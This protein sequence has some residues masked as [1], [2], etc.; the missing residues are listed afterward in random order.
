M[1]AWALSQTLVLLYLAA[2]PAADFYVAPNGSDTNPGTMA[3][4]F[5]SIERARGAVRGLV[6]EG[7]DKDVVVFVRGGTYPLDATLTFGPEDSGT[8][9]HAIT[10]A[11]YPGEKPVLSGGRAI[12]GWKQTDGG[13]WQVDLSA[14]KAIT[15]PF[16]QLFTDGERLTRGR[17]PNGDALLR[18]E[19]VSSDV[20][21]ITLSE[22]PSA[23]NLA[24]KG[25]ELVMYQNWSISRVGV[26]GSEGKTV[27]CA[28][29]VGWIGHGSATTASP[30]KPC[31]IENAPEFVDQPGEWYWDAQSN[32]LTYMAAEGEDPNDRE[33]VAPQLHKLIS[34]KGR[35]GAP[36]RNLHFEGLAFEH[37]GW[38]VED[39]GYL[40]IQA[41]HHGTHTQGPIYVLPMAIEFLEAVDC[42]VAQC[43]VAHTGA[44]GITFGAG[45]Q[46]NTVR[47]CELYDIGG[48]GIMVG[49]RG[50][51]NDAGLSGLIGD[52]ALSND[53]P[54]ASDVPK[55]NSIANNVLHHCAAV[56][57][58][59]VGIY[60]AFCDGTRI[61]HNLVHDMPYTGISIGFRWNES[62][63]SQRNALLECNHVHDVM[64]MLADGGAIYTLGYQP[65][66]V[67]RGNLLHHAHRSPFAHGG[68]P[69]NGIFFDQGSK[70]Y[71]VE[72]N[73]IYETSGEPIRF[74][75]THKDNLT[76]KDNSFGVAPGAPGFPEAAAAKAGPAP[77]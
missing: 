20:K 72:G 64:K 73:I 2:A 56:S 28:N 76:W 62:E 74:N 12:T 30:G 36:V 45:C 32:V 50:K 42:E 3:A 31:Y 54:Q 25:A 53:W 1:T 11:A 4:P 41:G 6:K 24:G 52:G 8:A 38:A 5:A 47:D 49:W 71:H 65:G 23:E 70:G 14:Q 33:F 63:T 17:Y 21:Q 26:A 18:V 68:A 69:N 16:R 67:L 39:Y 37:V 29:P 60:D 13:K 57:H 66:T 9:E 40:G 75:Q 77:R 7:L 22:A 35:P 61:T 43:R 59:C 55:D 51:S 15:H 34:V 48:N 10:Y 19:S 27:L 58:G 46:A 44:C